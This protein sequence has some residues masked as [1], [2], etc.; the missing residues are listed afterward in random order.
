MCLRGEMSPDKL[1]NY[2]YTFKDRENTMK[3]IMFGNVHSFSAPR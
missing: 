1:D 3:A 2:Y